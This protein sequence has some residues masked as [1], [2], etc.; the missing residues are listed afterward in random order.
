MQAQPVGTSAG[1]VETLRLARLP[2]HMVA[3]VA[4]LVRV[5]LW[6]VLAVVVEVSERRVR[7]H[8]R[9]QRT[10][11]AVVV[12]VRLLLVSMPQAAAVVGA[13]ASP[14]ERLEALVCTPMTVVL[15]LLRVEVFPL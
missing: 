1:K 14:L 4:V 7:Q 3:E 9:Q 2:Q 11:E 15:A 12:V 8:L 10:V 5:L 6:Q 13:A